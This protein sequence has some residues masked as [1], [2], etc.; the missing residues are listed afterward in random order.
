LQC[1]LALLHFVVLTSFLHSHWNSGVE[2]LLIGT[3]V[4][5]VS[6]EISICGS[7]FL[8]LPE[9]C[10]GNC[11]ASCH[12]VCGTQVLMDPFV[13]IP[14]FWLSWSRFHFHPFEIFPLI[15]FS[16]LYVPHTAMNIILPF[17][18]SHRLILPCFT[19]ST[20]RLKSLVSHT[21]DGVQSA[22]FP[23]FRIL[24][25]QI[26]YADRMCV[27]RYQDFV[28]RLKVTYFVK[29]FLLLVWH[30]DYEIGRLQKAWRPYYTITNTVRTT[31]APSVFTRGVSN[32]SNM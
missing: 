30:F 18:I 20:K 32:S 14:M 10:I 15:H 9:R 6:S 7:F 13:A 2:Q 29:P 31:P 19:Q 3:A 21:L 1:K 16:R 17:S 8:L 24:L 25:H 26:Q 22:T 27:L 5:L 11:S 23:I 12:I 28:F 4:F